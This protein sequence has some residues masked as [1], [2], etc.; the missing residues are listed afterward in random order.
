MRFLLTAVLLL[1]LAAPLAAEPR[2]LYKEIVSGLRNAEYHLGVLEQMIHKRQPYN[3]RDVD[4]TTQNL[5]RLETVWAAA[6]AKLS[7]VQKP[8]HEEL[9]KQTWDM[10]KAQRGLAEACAS[11]VCGEYLVSDTRRPSP[12]DPEQMKRLRA[13]V[14]EL[15]QAY[16]ETRAR[17]AKRL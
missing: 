11:I 9:W 3:Q 5:T 7:Q 14:P 6:E 1:G 13:K 12:I 2:D 10:L 8:K 17:L 4:E 16:D 15:R